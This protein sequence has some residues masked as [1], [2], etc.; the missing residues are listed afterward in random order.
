MRE[1]RA[2]TEEQRKVLA[3]GGSFAFHVDSLVCLCW[4]AYIIMFAILFAM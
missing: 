1:G 3:E 2:V 4:N